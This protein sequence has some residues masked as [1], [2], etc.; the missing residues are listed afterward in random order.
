MS[1]WVTSGFALALS[2]NF[3]ALVSAMCANLDIEAMLLDG[4]VGGS[5]RSPLLIASLVAAVGA[6]VCGT[7]AILAHIRW[8]RRAEQSGR[9]VVSLQA[10]VVWPGAPSGALILAWIGCGREDLEY[11]TTIV[12]LLFGSIF[13][14]MPY[15]ADAMNNRLSSDGGFGA[16]RWRQGPIDAWAVVVP[17]ARQSPRDGPSVF[18]SF[19]STGKIKRALLSL[20]LFGFAA[21]VVIQMLDTSVAWGTLW[22]ERDD[23]D[24]CFAAALRIQGMTSPEPE[25]KEIRR[26]Y[27]RGCAGNHGGCCNN[28]SIML[29][30]GQ[31]GARDESRAQRLMERG[32][33]LG[34]TV[35]CENLKH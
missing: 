8:V 22:C 15:I 5:E 11:P 19:R 24:A 26:L 18:G 7:G 3:L 34:S 33:E 27:E 21:L 17:G 23:A 20:G 12:W 16:D 6:V 35:A 32:C 29:S 1:P 10:V 28:L 4:G 25:S 13:A 9:R 2:S 31:G 30:R 14:L